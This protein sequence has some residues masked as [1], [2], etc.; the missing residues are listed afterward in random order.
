MFLDT[1][2]LEK[3]NQ[4]FPGSS[5]GITICVPQVLILFCDILIFSLSEMG[6]LASLNEP[7]RAPSLC[8]NVSL[9]LKSY[10]LKVQKNVLKECVQ[11]TTM[12]YIRICNSL[13][14]IHLAG[15]SFHF[16]NFRLD[17]EQLRSLDLLY[18]SLLFQQSFF[19]IHGVVIYI[20]PYIWFGFF[21]PHIY[22]YEKGE[23]FSNTSVTHP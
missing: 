2:D 12:F 20:A 18:M 23:L 9:L 21:S 19:I 4:V 13:I 3:R 16:L 11:K 22:L 15:N 6:N 5:T 10:I 17:T 1:S 8:F 14:H 7:H